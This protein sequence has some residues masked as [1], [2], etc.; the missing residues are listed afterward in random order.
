MKVVQKKI[1]INQTI[2]THAD[3]LAQRHQDYVSEFVTRANGELYAILAEILKQVP[4]KNALSN[5]YDASSKTALTSKPKPIP[6]PL[7]WLSS[8]SHVPVAKLRMCMARYWT[9]P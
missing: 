3:L 4:S 6:K 9:L 8:T 7:H 2:I 5:R 1:D